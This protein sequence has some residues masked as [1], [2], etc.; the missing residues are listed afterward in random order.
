MPHLKIALLSLRI[1]ILSALLSIARSAYLAITDKSSTR[2]IRDMAHRNALRG[3]MK[4]DTGCLGDEL[5][6]CMAVLSVGGLFYLITDTAIS[7]TDFLPAIV[8][9]LGN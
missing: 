2:M 8:A 4:D 5:V 3:I 6:G 1:A 9:S 7:T